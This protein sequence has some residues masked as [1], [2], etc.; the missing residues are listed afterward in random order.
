MNKAP[1]VG[2]GL[3]SIIGQRSVGGDYVES[4]Q[5]NCDD[6]HAPLGA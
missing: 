3:D 5:G 6:N 2:F 4:T 1:F